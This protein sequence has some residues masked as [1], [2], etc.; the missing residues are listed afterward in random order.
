[1]VP[2]RRSRM[3]GITALMQRRPPKKLVSITWRNAS[4]EASSTGPPPGMPALLTRTSIGPCSA[5]T[6][7][8]PSRTEA[9]SSTSTLAR[10]I[11]SFSFP[12]IFRTSPLRSR[13]RIAATTVCPERASEID[14][15]RPMP[16]LDPVTNASAMTVFLPELRGTAWRRDAHNAPAPS[17]SGRRPKRDG[18]RD[19]I[20]PWPS[21]ERRVAPAKARKTSCDNQKSMLSFSGCG[22]STTEVS[23]HIIATPA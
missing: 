18:A 2:L 14:V 4:S 17:N 8:K 7:A 5:T 11:G 15:A 13:L 9:S 20:R 6:L 16:V 22:K 21:F 1:M 10:W 12:A 23:G 19:A 3:L